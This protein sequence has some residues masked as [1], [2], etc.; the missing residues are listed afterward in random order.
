M[1]G[2]VALDG[3]VQPS[4]VEVQGAESGRLARAC[5][6][7]A[8]HA[9]PARQATKAGILRSRGQRAG[10]CKGRV[11]GRGPKARRVSGVGWEN[12][13]VYAQQSQGRLREWKVVSARSWWGIRGQMGEEVAEVSSGQSVESRGGAGGGQGRRAQGSG[14][15]GV[16]RSRESDGRG[17]GSRLAAAGGGASGAGLGG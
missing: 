16:T 13:D 17:R 15:G 1:L 11:P 8:G 7:G 3:A 10:V 6:E 2:G 14:R 12:Q 9:S 4:H 5:R